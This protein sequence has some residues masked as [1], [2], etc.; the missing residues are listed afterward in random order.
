MNLR[1]RLIAVFRFR[2]LSVQLALVSLFLLV[3]ALT[4]FGALAWLLA[5]ASLE[6][7]LGRRLQSVASLSARELGQAEAGALVP[8]GKAAQLVQAR[9][10]ELARLGGLRA[11]LV[12]DNQGRVLVDSAGLETPGERYPYTRLDPAEWEQ[13]LLGHGSVTPLFVGRDGGYYKSAFEPLPGPRGRRAV[14]RAEASADFLESIRD[15]GWSLLGLGAVSLV[16]A[17]LLGVWMSRPLVRP[18]RGLIEASRR[19]ARGDFNARVELTRADELGQLAETFNEM[20]QDL[21][22]W[23]RQRE[24]LAALGEL[25]A[26]VVHEI[27]NPL[28]AIEG[29]A[30]L[31]QNKLKPKDPARA[32]A[33]D[34]QAEVKVA[35]QFLGDFLEYSRARPALLTFCDVGLV[36][37]D[38]LKVAFPRGARARWKLKREGERHLRATVDPGQLRQVLVNLLNNAREASPQ[39]GPIRAG[40]DS[41]KGHL[42][43]WVADLG[44]GIPEGDLAKLF[45]PFFTSKPMGT[46]LG[47]SIAHKLVEGLGGRI[48]VSSQ[49]GKGSVFTVYVP[50][51]PSRGEG[52]D[53]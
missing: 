45:L 10:A 53:A 5:A 41:Q 37:D 47:L 30:A 34:I 35:N 27:R 19:V 12:L 23:A 22:V 33:K 48:E 31:L 38:A 20:A 49:F 36:L 17:L 52:A 28:Q 43:L 4:I 3:V 14:V 15:F 8:G 25:A 21:G 44:R 46:G 50:V 7:E 40:L 51:R 6:K 32:Y 26:G 9:A 24:R 39:G 11:L 18:I 42:R 16:G 2:K 1:R 29:F 13:A